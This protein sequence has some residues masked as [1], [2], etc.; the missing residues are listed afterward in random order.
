[1]EFSAR[2]K[3]LATR[4]QELREHASVTEEATKNALILPFLQAL[5]YDTFDPRIVVPE[6][7]ADVGTKKGEKVDYAIKRDG[8]VII[9]IEAKCA[10]TCLDSGKAD[11]LHRYF[12]NTPTARLAI[13][14][15][16]VQYQFFSDLDKPNIMDDKPFMIFNFDK[17]EEALIPELKKLANDSFDVD[18]ALSAAQDLKHLRQIK[19]LIAQELASPSDTFVKH[20]VAQIYDGQL[21]ASVLDDFRPKISLAFD[22]YINDILLSRIQGIARPNTY[23]SV[24]D[25]PAEPAKGQVEEAVENES[26][27]VTTQE[28]IEGYLIIKAILCS[29]VD[30]ARVV[31]RDRQTYCGILLDDNNRKPLCRMH[32]NSVSVKYIGTFD[33]DKNETKH[34]IEKLDDIYQYADLLRT[35]VG[36]YLGEQ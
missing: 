18:V 12:H 7:T 19:Q 30:P 15:D 33:A 31:M 21:R 34:K 6:Y 4:I 22:H 2:V 11:Q 5:G 36:Y 35:T 27:I 13:L 32:F 10:G 20:F 24:L 16:G 14:T 9:L 28:E 23:A 17:L 29:V 25:E 8:E 26:G 3:A 1:M